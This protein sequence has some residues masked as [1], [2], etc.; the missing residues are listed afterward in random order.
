MKLSRENMLGGVIIVA[1][2]IVFLSQTYAF[3]GV[4]V[5]EGLH[6]MAYPKLLAWCLMAMG[7]LIFFSPS[8]KSQH[9]DIPLFSLRTAIVSAILVAY[10]VCLDVIGFGVT[11]FLA[12]CAIGYAMGWT[13]WKSLILSNLLGVGAIW[14]LFTYV[15]SIMLPRGLLF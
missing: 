10:A 4:D 7:G 14:A 3:E 6:P 8:K 12:A 2:S 11:S 13:N 9:S 1:I 15:L 5:D